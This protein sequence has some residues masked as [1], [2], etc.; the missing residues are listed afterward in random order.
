MKDNVHKISFLLVALITL[1]SMNVFGYS[2]QQP[3][4]KVSPRGDL[5]WA[6][7]PFVAEKGTDVRYIDYESGNDTRDGLSKSTAWKHHPLDP[8]ATGNAKAGIGADTYIFKRGVMYRGSLNGRLTGTAQRPIRLTIDPAWG[9]GEATIAGSEQVTGWTKGADRTDIPEAAKVWYADINFAPRAVWAVAQNGSITR[10]PLARTPNWSISDPEDV[11]SEWFVWQQPEWWTGKNKTTVNG[12]TMHLGIDAQNLTGKASDYVGGL[13]WSEWGIVM[14][15]PFASLIESF[16]ANK[17]G[18]GFQGF[19]YNDSGQIITGNRYF[20][21]DKPNFLDS[22][23]EFWFNKTGAGGRLYMRLPGDANPNSFRI[24]AACRTNLMDFNELKHVRISGLSFRFSNLF[25]DLTARQFVHNDVQSAAVRLLGTGKDVKISNNSFTHVNMAIRMKAVADTDSMDE[26]VICDNDIR[27]TD[28]GAMDLEGSARWGKSDPPFAFF[29]DLKVLRNRLN[30]I[31]RRPVRSDSAHAINIGFPETLEVAGNILER[32]YGAGIFVFMGK[33]SGETSDIPL[34]RGF[35]HHNKAVQT[36][37]AANDWGGIETWQGGPVYVYNNISANPCGY[38]NWTANPEGNS[39]LGFAFYLDGAFKNYYFNNIA[40]GANNDLTSKYCNR[41]AFYQATP[42]ILNAFFNNTA[43]R[44]AEGSGWSPA[45]G[46]QL[47]LGNVWDDISQFVFGHG[48]QKE[49]EGATYSNY[50]LDSMAYSRNVFSK[51]PETF[52]HLEGTGFG[53][54]NLDGFKEAAESQKMLAYDVGI[55]T[56][57]QIMHNPAQGDMRPVPNSP[58]AGKGVKFF[59]PWSLSRTVGEWN[60]RCNNKTP[61]VALDEHWYMSPLVVN[62]DNYYALPRHDLQGTNLEASDYINGPLED[63]CKG[64]IR[65]NPARGTVLTLPPPAGDS[66]ST[67]QPSEKLIQSPAD[68]LEVTTDSMF[69]P[70]KEHTVTV[71]L[72]KTFPGQK[73]MVHLHWLKT[74]GWGGYDSHSFYTPDANAGSYDFTLNPSAHDNLNAYSLLI[75]MSPTGNWE[76]VTENASV[77]VPYGQPTPPLPSRMPGPHDTDQNNFLVEVIFQAV[78]GNQGTALVSCIGER[79]Y[80]LGFDN[81]GALKFRVKADSEVSV[82]SPGTVADGRW[83]HAIAEADRSSGA[84]RLYI[85]GKLAAQQNATLSGSA[86]HTG[87]LMV[88][89]GDGQATA[90]S[91]AIDF[92]RIALG[93]LEDSK[94]TIDE[95]YTW[96]FDG[97]FLRDFTGRKAGAS[98]TAGAIDSGSNFTTVH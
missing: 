36:L 82:T 72:K 86:R 54:T 31:G 22:P 1:L 47:F 66:Q 53:Q 23:G 5:E 37:L 93:S 21:E 90:F 46:R 91:G 33:G 41:S 18:I 87:N 15:T 64:A 56:Q 14:G 48:K 74:D 26:V 2:W 40:W 75:G 32:T 19:W 42:T 60:F 7:Q 39:R 11:M 25:W 28:F 17:K 83:H 51:I 27:F 68:W 71:K 50:Q 34:T 85:D 6:P 49:D 97:P 10:I 81:S 77:S 29:G 44:F 3:H 35:V 79:G 24:E 43:Y 89:K 59:V 13:V 12:V 57:A 55:A 69:E 8:A 95:L 45:G 88:G 65:F 38:W 30:E 61:A 78:A 92:L 52:G 16:D 20:L 58:A 98:R 70:G 67:E 76:G 80:E 4:A 73:L 96:Q 62:R 94:T 9:S 84:L 63:W